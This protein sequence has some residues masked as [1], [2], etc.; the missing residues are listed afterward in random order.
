LVEFH[1]QNRRPGKGKAKTSLKA[2]DAQVPTFPAS[3]EKF[4]SRANTFIWQ[5]IENPVRQNDPENLKWREGS[6]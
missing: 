2:D 3:A 5:E 6:D 1:S 4:H